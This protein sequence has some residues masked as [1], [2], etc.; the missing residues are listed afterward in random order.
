VAEEDQNKSEQASRYKLEQAG[1]K[2]SAP[3]SMDINSFAILL[4]A[5]L[6]LSFFGE[7]MAM[8][9]LRSSRYLF[10]NAAQFHLSAE[11]SAPWMVLLFID[12]LKACVP[13][14]LLV[15][16]A[17]IVANVS[18]TGLIFSTFPLKPDFKRI[19]P[20]EGFKRLF[21]FK[22]VFEAIKSGFKMLA[23]ATALYLVLMRL[24]PGLLGLPQ[25]SVQVLDRAVLQDLLRVLRW[26][27]VALI[28]VF[29][30]DLIY[31]RRS[32][33]KKMMMS[34]REV[35]D[36]HKQREGD[37]RIRSKIRELQREARKR[38]KALRNVKDADVLITNPTRLAIAIR[39]DREQMAAPTVVAKGAGELAR[40]MKRMAQRHQVPVVENKPLAR[41]LFRRSDIDAQVPEEFFGPLARLLTW[42]YAQRAAAAALPPPA[43]TG[44]APATFNPVMQHV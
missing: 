26:C 17:A 32:F 37:P 31:V 12:A 41:A 44:P 3:R 11:N 20:A 25:S 10:T 16:L 15:V 22:I 9:L 29:L 14:F 38:S 19:N 40:L 13:L 39:Y 35:T 24:L 30:I 36:E 33:M 18:Q 28:P 1:K 8:A 5:I 27:L 6:A 7:K 43:H 21:S 4:A 42:V 2:G 34:R 23:L